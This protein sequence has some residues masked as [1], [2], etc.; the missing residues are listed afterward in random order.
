VTTA[1]TTTQTVLLAFPYN[2]AVGDKY[3]CVNIKEG[4]SAVNLDSYIMGINAEALTTTYGYYVYVH[5]LN[6]AE[7]GKEYVVFS[8]ST[9][10]LL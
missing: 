6:L 2:S 8:F 4:F 9:R 5:E 10:H 3:T 1:G 7:A